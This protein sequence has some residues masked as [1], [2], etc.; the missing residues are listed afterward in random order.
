MVNMHKSIGSK[1]IQNR[2]SIWKNCNLKKNSFQKV[3][4]NLL[5]VSNFK[6]AMAISTFKDD[7]P[8]GNKMKNVCYS[9]SQI[10]SISE[11]LSREDHIKEYEASAGI[12]V[13]NFCLHLAKE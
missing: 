13:N 12:S 11:V 8:I 2:L 1:S 5:C 9:I 6:K 3:N 7:R 4:S 10:I